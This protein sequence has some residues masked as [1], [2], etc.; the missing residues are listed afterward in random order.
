[1]A[2]VFPVYFKDWFCY[3]NASFILL[4]SFKFIEVVIAFKKISFEKW[5]RL[6]RLHFCANL[7]LIVANTYTT[8]D[9]KKISLIERKNISPLKKLTSANHQTMIRSLSMY[10]GRRI[11]LALFK[12]SS[13]WCCSQRQY[14]L[15]SPFR[16]TNNNIFT[17]ERRI[18]PLNICL[19]LQLQLAI[20]PSAARPSA[21]N[22]NRICITLHWSADH[23]LTWNQ[24]RNSK[25]RP[26]WADWTG[27]YWVH[28]ATKSSPPPKKASEFKTIAL[29]DN[30]C[31]CALHGSMAVLLKL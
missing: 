27:F 10:F 14:F 13:C 9:T 23:T 17:F 5:K 16:H 8:D 2:D 1:M 18:I 25:K 11:R 12:V 6:A 15:A 7:F 28:V 4:Q 21:D 20:A 19:H 30:I 24:Q 29:R 26:L 22:F 31:D 3:K